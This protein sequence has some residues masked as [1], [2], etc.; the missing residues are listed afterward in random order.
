MEYGS[1]KGAAEA[2]REEEEG[3]FF[4]LFELDSEWLD[5][6]MEEA[7]ALLSFILR[8]R[9]RQR[10]HQREERPTARRSTDGTGDARMRALI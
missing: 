3:R 1:V 6:N 5:A 10:L 8:V 4:M 7:S 9:G 2:E